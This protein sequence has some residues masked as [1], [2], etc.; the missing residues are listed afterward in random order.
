MGD[1]L[2]TWGEL[3][4]LGARTIARRTAEVLEVLGLLLFDTTVALV[5]AAVLL[6][7]DVVVFRA[8]VG[9][10]RRERIITRL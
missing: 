6:P 1:N 7:V 3:S 2:R 8:V 5:A 4:G 9:R 10:F